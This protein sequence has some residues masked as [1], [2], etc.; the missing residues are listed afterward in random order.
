MKKLIIS[1]AILQGLLITSCTKDISSYN[2]E[3]KRAANVPAGTL[4]SNATRNL[5]DNLVSASVNT[6]PFRFIVKHWSM[7]TYQDEAQFDFSTRNIPQTWWGAMYRDVLTDYKE[8]AKI[9]TDDATLLEGEKANKLA[10][11]DIM[12]VYVFANLVTTFGDIPYSQ[13]LDP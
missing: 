3:T 1:I 11:V 12:Q 6:N 9:I 13:A 2:D 8:S 10:I 4:F 5:S 7:A